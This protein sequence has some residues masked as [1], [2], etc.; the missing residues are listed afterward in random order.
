MLKCDNCGFTTDAAMKFC[1]ECGTKLTSPAPVT[2]PVP[3]GFV[4]LKDNIYTA[5]ALITDPVLG[6]EVRKVTYF[7]NLTGQTSVMNYP[8]TQ[9]A[10]PTDISFP[11][12]AKSKKEKPLEATK[13]SVPTTA[14]FAAN[15]EIVTA[16]APVAT[17]MVPIIPNVPMDFSNMNMN[18]GFMPKKPSKALHIVIYAVLAVLLVACLYFSGVINKLLPADISSFAPASAMPAL[19][20][21]GTLDSAPETPPEDTPAPVPEDIPEELP[22][23]T[24]NTNTQGQSPVSESNNSVDFSVLSQ[25]EG[26][27]FH[28]TSDGVEYI[29]VEKSGSGYAITVAYF[30]SDVGIY[31]T[32]NSVEASADA[33]HVRFD[34]YECWLVRGDVGE[35]LYSYDDS[36]YSLFNFV[37]NTASEASDYYFRLYG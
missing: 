23:N 34:G 35:L 8:T 33:Y 20:A 15:S 14:T 32:V 18:Y 22:E 3:D 28:E 30:A 11:S 21:H 24:P 25:F 19:V 17:P 29:I 13:A 6:V 37:G 4:Q 36:N 7:D 12:G 10:V 1:P 16:P 5:E 2:F 9:A 27:W 31:G 26:H